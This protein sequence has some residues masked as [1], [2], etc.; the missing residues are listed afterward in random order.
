MNRTQ[1][2]KNAITL[3]VRTK[4]NFWSNFTASPG[5]ILGCNNDN[6]SLTRAERYGC[7][8]S[9]GNCRCG[10]FTS[11]HHHELDYFLFDTEEACR[12]RIELLTANSGGVGGGGDVSSGRLLI[13]RERDKA[14]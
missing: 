1:L 3:L 5:P 8:F 7:Y 4:V 11:C 12:S 6:K 2:R 9:G 14:G 10:N 13:N